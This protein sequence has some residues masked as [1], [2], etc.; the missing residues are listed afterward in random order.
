[1]LPDES[2]TAASIGCSGWAMEARFDRDVMHLYIKKKKE[3][4]IER[5]QR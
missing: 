4:F 3:V 1:M 2:R 5:E